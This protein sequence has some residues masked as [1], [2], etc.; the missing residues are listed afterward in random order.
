MAERVPLDERILM[1][2]NE[3]LAEAAIKAGCRAFFGYPITPASEISA[4]M[5]QHM[6][7]AG[8]AFLQPESEISSVNMVFGAAGVGARAMT[9]SSSPG[10]SLMSEGISFLA[11]AEL[12]CLLVNMMRVGPGL[13]GIQPSQADYLQATR[14]LGHGDFRVIV[15]APANVQ[16]LVDFVFDAFELAE[17]YRNPALILADGVLGQMMEPVVFRREVDPADLPEPSWSTTGATDRPKRIIKS[18]YLDPDELEQHNLKL[19]AKYTRLKQEAVRWKTYDAEGSRLLI[20]AYGTSARVAYHAME[21]AEERDLPVG[22]FRPLTVYPYPHEALRQVVEEEDIE[23]VLVVE[24]SAGQMIEDVR[25]AV[26]GR[27]PI[28]FLGRSGGSIP[29]SLEVLDKVRE[30][31]VAMA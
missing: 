28:D 30:L 29:T 11:G 2:G 14:G 25:L 7:E 20:V 24:L 10:I 21:L 18:L 15:L 23:R 26:E 16:E 12:P 5:A 8:G 31:A 17:S 19:Q 3:A 13:G 9:A 6:G 22:L 1:K 4:Y 27:C